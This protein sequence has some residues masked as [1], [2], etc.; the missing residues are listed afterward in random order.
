MPIDYARNQEGTVAVAYCFGKLTEADVL[1]SLSF[2]FGSG[3]IEPGLDRIV[4]VDPAAE[5]HELDI[6]ALRRIQQHVFNEELR[7]GPEVGFRSVL[8]HSSPMQR[9]LMQLYKA[10][11]DAMKLPQVEFSIVP[12][13]DEAWRILGLA[14]SALRRRGA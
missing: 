9:H 8:V 10:I 14:P 1:N 11:W 4:T 6:E 7:N 3:H 5:L 13:E 12:S 2:A